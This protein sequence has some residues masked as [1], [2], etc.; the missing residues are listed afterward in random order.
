V[1]N[2]V[3]IRTDR[4]QVGDWVNVVGLTDFREGTKVADVDVPFGVGTVI[5]PE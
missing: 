2:G 1:D 3:A 4:P 5:G